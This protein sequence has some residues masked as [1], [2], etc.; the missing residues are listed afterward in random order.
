MVWED[1]LKAAFGGVA[2][3]LTGKNFPQNVRALRLVCEEVLRGVIQDVNSYEELLTVLEN[4]GAE[5][6][7]SKLWLHC[8]FKPVLIMMLFVRAEKGSRMGFAFVCRLLN[9]A[10]LL[11]LQDTL[12]MQGT[13]CIT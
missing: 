5:S 9:D 12:I 4:K 6:R 8:L 1:V 13:V 2:R 11:W 10:L 7:T 3:M